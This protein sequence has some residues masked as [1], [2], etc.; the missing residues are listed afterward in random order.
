FNLGGG[1]LVGIGIAF[2]SFSIVMAALGRIVP[3]EKRSWAF[4]IATASGSLGQFIFAPLGQALIT[5]YGWQQA[6]VIL[7]ASTL[8]IVPFAI[9]LLVQNSSGSRPSAGE[10]DLT[11]R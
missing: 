9:P 1:L 2:S 6:M 11:M 3:P 8:V 4:G 7:A 5:A 10:A